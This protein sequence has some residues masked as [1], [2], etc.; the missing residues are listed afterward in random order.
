MVLI[1]EIIRNIM[2]SRV[3]VTYKT[4]L[5]RI[6][7]FIELYTFTDFWTTGNTALS[8]FYTLC[9]KKKVVL[10]TAVKNSSHTSLF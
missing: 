7:V 5:D 4:G 1:F 10:V 6:I 2:L 9:F 3:D 8:I